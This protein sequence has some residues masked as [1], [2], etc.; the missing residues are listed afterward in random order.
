MNW[1]TTA[2]NNDLV[3]R[4]EAQKKIIAMAKD[5]GIAGAFKVFYDDE[6]VVNP[7]DLLD[8]VDLTLVKVSAVLDN[9][10]K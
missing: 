7:S 5:Q 1:D 9:A 8:Q 6:I 2:N 10:T 4:E 3:S